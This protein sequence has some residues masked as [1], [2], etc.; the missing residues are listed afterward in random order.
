MNRDVFV[1]ADRALNRV[2]EQITDDQWAMK[3]PANFAR[4]GEPEN[5]PSLRTLIAYHAFDDAW[6]LDMLTGQTIEEIGKTK[7]EGDLLGT[8]PR[9]AFAAIVDKARAAAEQVTD[10]GSHGALLVRRLLDARIL[11]ADQHVS[12]L[13]GVGHRQGDRRSVSTPLDELVQGLWDELSPVADSY[14][15]YGVFPAA[16]PVPDDASLMQRLLGL[17]G[18]DPGIDHRRPRNPMPMIPMRRA[19]V[20]SRRARYAQC[21]RPRRVAHLQAPTRGA[22]H[23]PLQARLTERPPPSSSCSATTSTRL[24]PTWVVAGVEFTGPVQ[25]TR[26]GRLVRMRIPGGGEVGLLDQPLGRHRPRPRRLS[27]ARR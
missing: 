18:K 3:M 14:R 22:G 26:F 17:T 25:E 6:V 5:V 12:R 11:L 13:A 16:I 19:R 24:S 23:P 10:P 20:L 27:V 8:D 9:T 7:F 21:R 2:V 1:L 15:Q 4:S